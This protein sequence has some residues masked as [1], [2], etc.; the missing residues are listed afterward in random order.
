VPI[1]DQGYQHWSGELSGHAWRWLAIARHGVRVGM[2]EQFVKILIFGACGPAVVLAAFLCLWG[3]IERN[4]AS[5]RPFLDFLSHFGFGPQVLADPRSFRV[6]FW[7]ICY[8]VF[9]DVEIFAAMILVLLVGRQLIGQDL[10]FNAMPLYFS[11]PLRRIDYFLGKLAV[12]GGFLG[13]VIIVPAVVAYIL[14]LAFSLDITILRDTFPLLLSV[15]LYGLVITISAGTLILAISSLS[16]S[17]RIVGLIWIGLWF[18]SNIS[19]SMLNHAYLMEHR[20]F[21]IGRAGFAEARLSETNWR[22]IVSYTTDLARVGQQLLGTDACWRKLA[23]LQTPD[24]R[25]VFLMMFLG[26]QYPWYWSAAVLIGLFAVAAW[27]LHTRVRSMDRL[28]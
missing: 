10:R 1:I 3:L 22:P 12:I 6:E 17:S 24:T 2:R 14:G 26:P 9:M 27:I 18:V 4:S 16:R 21:G 20:E 13:M 7:T 23:D 15:I 11:R 19:A 25:G 5:F 28:K 8:S